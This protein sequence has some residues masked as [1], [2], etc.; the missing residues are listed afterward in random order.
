MI[1][2]FNLEYEYPPVVRE[3][4]LRGMKIEK[5]NISSDT[6]YLISLCDMI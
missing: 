6:Y 3:D 2:V 1:V 5:K 4:I